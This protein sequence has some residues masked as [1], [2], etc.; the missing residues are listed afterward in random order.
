M[1]TQATIDYGPL[2][3]LIGSWHGDKGMDVA[4]ESDGIERNPYYET[5]TF[6]AAGDVT[7]AEQQQLA[8]LFYRQ[9]VSRH[10]NKQVFHDECGY[11]MW[12]AET[13]VVMHSLTIPRA[14]TLIAGG[15]YHGPDNSDNVVLSVTAK[16]DDPDWQITQSPFMR[17]NARTD[18][19]HHQITLNGDSIS[20][21]E[22]TIL[23]IYGKRFE[24]TDQNRLKRA[25]TGIS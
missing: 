3:G 19:F 25:K 14:V 1:N 18:E 8:V 10:S 12:D 11:W 20:Y 17:D 13:K 24:H 21:N 7:N 4:P 6:E 2:T 22:T 15:H 23:D 5:I 16:R 9:Q